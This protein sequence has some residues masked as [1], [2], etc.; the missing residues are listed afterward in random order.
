M[1][2]GRDVA[3]DSNTAA[4]ARRGYL[5]L[6]GLTLA[7]VLIVNITALA[8]LAR[9]RMDVVALVADASGVRVGTTVTVAGVDAGRVTGIEIVP[10]GDS[11]EVALRLRLEGDA[12]SVLRLD[13]DVRTIRRRFIGEPVVHLEPGTAAAPPLGPGD[14]LRGRGRIDPMDLLARGRDFPAALDSLMD[15]ARRLQ[16]LA[17][18]R[19]PELELLERRV[20]AA[21]EAAGALSRSAEG[22]SLGPMLAEG[23]IA[24]QVAAL[25]TRLADVT[26]AV[27]TALGRF[28]PGADADA[29]PLAR[30]LQ[31]LRERVAALQVELTT[32]QL[33]MEEGRGLI[34]RMGRDTAL[35]VAVRG[36]QAQIDTVRAEA[37]SI[38]LRMLLP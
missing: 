20:L 33:R 3:R 38:V 2:P 17:A 28:A 15:S 10:A 1:H 22:G 26:E 35:Q 12:P 32:L 19:Q 18:A 21:V 36:V 30:S 25:R 8:D 9:P 14:T 13:S 24:D 27:S 23:G 4:R 29:D 5:I 31:G 11:A 37:M 7:A 16:G 6:V 34:G